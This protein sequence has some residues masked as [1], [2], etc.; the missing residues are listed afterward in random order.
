MIFR[1]ESRLLALTVWATL[2]GPKRLEVAPRT[3]S[4]TSPPRLSAHE[5]RNEVRLSDRWHMTAK[6]PAASKPVRW[7]SKS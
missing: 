4:S 6:F 7:G 3:R 1:A 2:A 5:G